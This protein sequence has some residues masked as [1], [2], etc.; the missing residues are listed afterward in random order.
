MIVEPSSPG[1]GL[2]HPDILTGQVGNEERRVFMTVP[3]ITDLVV[4]LREYA[5]V[6]TD[7]TLYD[8][9][10]ALEEARERFLR[11]RFKHRAVLVVDEHQ[12]I[13]G[14]VR[15]HE[16]IGHLEPGYQAMAGPGRPARS[17]L[18]PAVIKSTIKEYGLWK[19]PLDEVCRGAAQYPVKDFM[20]HFTENEYI[21]EDAPLEEAIHQLI[22]GQYQSLLVTRKREVVGVLRLTDIFSEVCLMVKENKPI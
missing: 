14:K 3:K 15:P 2:W 6:S 22:L 12:K 13:V 4:S 19:L 8:A 18:T 17:G 16:I 7:A 9:V 20:H 1:V 5:S 10:V 11:R 21:E